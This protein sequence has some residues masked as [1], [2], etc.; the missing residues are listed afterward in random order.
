[1]RQQ[2]LLFFITLF[3]FPALLIVSFVLSQTSLWASRYNAALAHAN[4]EGG[5]DFASICPEC[6]TPLS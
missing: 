5:S 2:M 3:L 4:L 6:R 1:M